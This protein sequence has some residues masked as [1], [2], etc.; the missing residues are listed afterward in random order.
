MKFLQNF[1][2]IKY[3]AQ[4]FL[5]NFAH[6]QICEPCNKFTYFVLRFL[7]ALFNGNIQMKIKSML[8]KE[9][10]VFV[11][12]LDTLKVN[13]IASGVSSKLCL[14]FSDH[15]LNRSSLFASICRVN[16]CMAKM[17]NDSSGAKYF[18]KNNTIYFNENA[19]TSNLSA[20]AMHEC[21]HFI[22]EII[23]N[24]ENIVKMGLSDGAYG[25][26]LNEAA[27]QLMASEANLEP[28]VA[29]KYYNI[30]LNTISPNYYPLEC[31]LVSQIIYFTGSYPLYHSTLNSNDVFKNTFVNKSNEK[32]YKIVV[33][34]L[35]ELL[36]LEN[37]LNYF[38]TELH[39]AKKTREITLLNKLI[40]SKKKAI[41]VLFLRTQN[42][43]MKQFFTNEFNSIRT[44]DDIVEFKQR[45][46]DYKNH[47]GTT[48]NYNFYNNLYVSM[49][50]ALG[51][52]KAYIEEFGEIN[53]YEPTTSTSLMLVTDTKNAFSFISILFKKVKKLFGYNQIDAINDSDIY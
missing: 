23:D 14:A 50:D 19:D 34:N 17:P 5:Q 15:G 25:I 24:S 42:V 11:R 29:E 4:K 45:L 2:Y 40:E 20:L 27:V 46:Y 33:K 43:I 32:T 18:Y 21:I 9:G 49:I 10:I 16:M 36:T 13:T 53:L 7:F 22:Q 47:I 28:S 26:G 51:E 38:R 30:A 1:H 31:N 39:Y 3:I 44:L 35:D 6:E 12:E 8:K 37:D 48:G 41:S 52:K